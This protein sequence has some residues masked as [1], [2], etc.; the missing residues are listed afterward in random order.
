MLIS[1][2]S[3]KELMAVVWSIT[4]DQNSEMGPP[5]LPLERPK[6]FWC[7]EG[8]SWRTNDPNSHGKCG[9]IEIEHP[10]VLIVSSYVAFRSDLS[11][12]TS[13][14]SP[15]IWNFWIRP[16][17][18]S[19]WNWSLRLGFAPADGDV[20]SSIAIMSSSTMISITVCDNQKTVLTCKF[21]FQTKRVFEIFN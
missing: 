6:G 19:V 10:Q 9:N 18:R 11:A 14:L 17:S 21:N 5:W 4:V 20:S 13:L 12:A 15:K 3:C 16:S 1:S 2:S 7:E 8:P